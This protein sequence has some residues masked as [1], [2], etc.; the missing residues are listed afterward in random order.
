MKAFIGFMF[1]MFAVFG[2][3]VA[4]ALDASDAI[5]VVQPFLPAWAQ[6]VLVIGGALYTSFVT[7]IR[8]VIPKETWAKTGKAGKVIDAV[9]AG[10][11]GHT[12]NE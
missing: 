12:K 6:L 3:S 5:A 8:P 4:V 7:V 10:N 11:W 2:C 9:I 1:A